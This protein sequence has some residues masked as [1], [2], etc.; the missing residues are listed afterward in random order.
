MPTVTASNALCSSY[1]LYISKHPMEKG[2]ST[3]LTSHKGNLKYRFTHSSRAGSYLVTTQDS[4]ENKWKLLSGAIQLL[5]HIFSCLLLT[6]QIQHWH[7]THVSNVQK[8]KVAFQKPQS[9]WAAPTL[10]YNLIDVFLSWS[11]SQEDPTLQITV[12]HCLSIINCSP[13]MSVLLLKF[14]CHRQNPQ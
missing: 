12:R 7:P 8:P 13:T 9:L 6:T 14:T 10:I 5:I 2:K 3:L 11:A 4:Q 1:H